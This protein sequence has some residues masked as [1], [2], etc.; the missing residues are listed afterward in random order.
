M[1]R[2]SQPP[3]QPD[4]E[5]WKIT[6]GK[7]LCPT[8]DLPIDWDATASVHRHEDGT[9]ICS[10]PAQPWHYAERGAGIPW[11]LLAFMAAVGVFIGGLAVFA[12]LGMG[13]IG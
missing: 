7:F 6:P 4:G 12:L 2:H 5:E 8:C 9:E 11:A 13:W 3:A 1:G 10:G